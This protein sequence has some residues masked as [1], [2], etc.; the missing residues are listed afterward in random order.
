MDLLKKNLGIN[1]KRLRKEKGLTQQQLA[2]KAG[3]DYPYLGMIERGEKNPTLEFIGKIAKGLNVETYQLFLLGNEEIF[4][5]SGE[6][7]KDTIQKVFS[8]Y[9]KILE[10]SLLN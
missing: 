6:T 3:M 8:M 7:E 10:N 2:D 4:I 9:N 1:I 5:L